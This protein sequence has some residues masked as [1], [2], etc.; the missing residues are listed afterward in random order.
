MQADR[1]NRSIRDTVGAVVVELTEVDVVIDGLQNLF[2][3]T[4]DRAARR[5]RSTSEAA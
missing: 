5:M 2:R 1:G 3:E 4:T